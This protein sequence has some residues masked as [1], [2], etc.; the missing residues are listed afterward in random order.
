MKMRT[1]VQKDQQSQQGKSGHLVRP[2]AAER[3]HEVHPLLHLQHTIG[4]QSVRRLLLAKPNDRKAVSDTAASDRFGHDFSRIPLHAKS[5]VKIQSKLAINAPGDIYEEEADRV[6][7]QVMRMPE[8][9]L[10]RACPCGGGCPKCQTEQVGQEYERL[11]TKRIQSS[12]T[13][14]IAAPPIVHEVLA[15]PGQPLD[16]ATRIF[17]ESRFGHDFSQV[18]VHADAKAAESALAVSALAYTAGR[19]VVFS[20]G[21]YEPNTSAGRK[22]LAHELVHIVQQGT[23]TAA[24]MLRRHTTSDCDTSQST[25]IATAITTAQSNLRA[26]I[27]QFA[28]IR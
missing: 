17:M 16:P 2:I 5:S 14:Q 23:G 26:V 3:S 4:N 6:S 8:P 20:A 13:G 15:A 22:L 9:Q 27:T 10:Q 19:N 24:G 1:H 11:Q 21:R 12:D 28:R 7:E 25:L 18:R